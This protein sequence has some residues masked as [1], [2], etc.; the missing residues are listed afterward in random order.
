M[1]PCTY[2]TKSMLG[3]SDGASKRRR[4]CTG[5]Q[6]LRGCLVLQC[7]HIS[8]CFSGA[9]K[10]SKLVELAH[11]TTSPQTPLLLYGL[12]AQVYSDLIEFLHLR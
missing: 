3:H 6:G 10:W 4:H 8:R 2:G 5:G 7:C 11:V 1:A 9:T 12:W